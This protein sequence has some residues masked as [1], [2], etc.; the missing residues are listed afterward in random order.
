[1][2]HRVLI[3]DESPPSRAALRYALT[4][5]SSLE[6]VGEAAD[7][8]MALRRLRE[9]APDVIAMDVFLRAESGVA[10]VRSIM[11]THATPIVLVSAASPNDPKIVFE[12]MCAGIV[13]ICTKLPSPAHADYPQLR[14]RLLR[15]LKAL[16]S[17]PVGQR[18]K[19]RPPALPS[20]QR[21]TPA[22]AGAQLASE[23]V[24]DGMLLLGASTGGPPVLAEV[25]SAL[26]KPFPLPI[27]VVQHMAVNF[28]RSFGEWLAQRAGR[29]VSV[30]AADCSATRGVIHLPADDHH[31]VVAEGG[32]L[33]LSSGPARGF[34]RPSADV[35]FSSAARL[36]TA[37]QMVAVV[38]TGMSNDGGHG[39]HEL[40]KAGAH[41]LVQQPTTCTVASMPKH[42]IGLGAAER[43]LVPTEIA[44]AIA[45]HVMRG[46]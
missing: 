24:G 2:A 6:V 33:M 19:S 40:R 3:I 18:G 10:L 46:R 25:L 8:A 41:T 34:F 16:A 36:P 21:G 44:R 4:G 43:I 35:M 13:E 12:A 23:L 29:P 30:V 17:V 26:P 38:L 32:R 7:G 22:A 28:T 39:L 9:L 27:A 20:L 42:A 15:T 31:L 11:E 45:R 5:E 1:M 37:S 14:A